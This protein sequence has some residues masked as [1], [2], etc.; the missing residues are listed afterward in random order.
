MKKIMFCFLILIMSLFY[1]SCVK[2]GD[3]PDMEQNISV[4]SS[5][6]QVLLTLPK[7]DYENIQ[8]I[9]ISVDRTVFGNKNIVIDIKGN[10]IYA[11]ESIVEFETNNFPID[12]DDFKCTKELL[13]DV[14]DFNC[15]QHYDEIWKIKLKSFDGT[16]YS[17]KMIF[18]INVSKNVSEVHERKIDYKYNRTP[19]YE[20]TSDKQKCQKI[21]KSSNG[22][23]D[24]IS[25]SVSRNKDIISSFNWTNWEPE[26]F[27]YVYQFEDGIKYRS[28]EIM[29]TYP[30]LKYS[31]ICNAYI[32]EHQQSCTPTLQ[33]KS[34]GDGT[35]EV[36]GIDNCESTWV[37]IPRKDPNGDMV[38]AI[39][40]N[41]FA[42]C[43]NLIG[44][45][46]P[47]TCTNIKNAFMGCS[48]LKVLAV[49]D[50]ISFSTLAPV[51]TNLELSH[52]YIDGNKVPDAISRYV[53]SHPEIEIITLKS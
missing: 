24:K 43:K 21:Y 51:S 15:D 49:S 9:Q 13:F 14:N 32:E 28:E 37:R 34:F 3:A 38:V 7:L 8:A 5:N 2:G 31:D 4:T 11:K 10:K 50:E 39:G 40:R 33:Y 27:R 22:G 23:P 45:I 47:D 30:K 12:W 20:I 41:A 35:C 53:K 18:K 17:F 1:T 44:I 16:F 52:I 29:T 26:I 19:I 6:R 42:G 46:L 36:C 25:F 48:S